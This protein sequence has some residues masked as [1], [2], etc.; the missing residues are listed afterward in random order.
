MKDSVRVA[1][2]LEAFKSHFHTGTTPRLTQAWVRSQKGITA[3]A[4][5]KLAASCALNWTV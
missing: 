2:R 3:Q 4:S 1:S 5:S